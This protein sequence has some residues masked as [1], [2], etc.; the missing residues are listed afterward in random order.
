M[1]I[2]GLQGDLKGGL[3]GGD[4]PPAPRIFRFYL[5]LLTEADGQCT[6]VPKPGWR[7][8][9]DDKDFG[10]FLRQMHMFVT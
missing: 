9:Q 1:N 3:G 10:V 2:G 8:L 4:L 6:P 5:G 7:G